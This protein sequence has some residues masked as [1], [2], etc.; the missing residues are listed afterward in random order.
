MIKIKIYDDWNTNIEIINYKEYICDINYKIL[1]NPV[2]DKQTNQIVKYKDSSQ[3]L[4]RLKELQKIKKPTEL[5]TQE[6][7]FLKWNK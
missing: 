3:G 4:A 6:L 5:E 1:D 7:E 2:V